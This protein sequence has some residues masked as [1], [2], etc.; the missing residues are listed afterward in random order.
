M[1]LF[2]EPP[3][4]PPA[5]QTPRDL[6]PDHASDV[7]ATAF[8]MVTPSFGFDDP[9]A[10]DAYKIVTLPSKA[11]VEITADYATNSKPGDTKGVVPPVDCFRASSQTEMPAV[12]LVPQF[13]MAET[14]NG[15]SVV[16]MVPTRLM[17]LEDDS[18]HCLQHMWCHVPV[19]AVL[20]WL[21]GAAGLIAAEAKS[22]EEAEARLASVASASLPAAL[23]LVPLTPPRAAA[24]L[25]LLHTQRC[26]ACN[27]ANAKALL[28]SKC[29]TAWY[30]DLVCQRNHWKLHRAQCK[31][32][33]GPSGPAGT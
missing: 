29:K 26:L 9:D 33:A 31:V 28:C 14:P 7:G 15:G 30:C 5:P 10:Y 19:A 12:V 6:Y 2:K 4:A 3:A 21:R 22:V 20:K 13:P 27:R 16:F 24:V 8:S 23:P 17:N 32:F 18:L 11:V 25:E 1:F